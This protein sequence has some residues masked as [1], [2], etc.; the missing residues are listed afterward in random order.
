MKTTYF[1][2]TV[3]VSAQHIGFS[4]G[5]FD[6]VDLSGFR[7]VDEDD[8]LG[9]NAIRVHGFCLPGRADE[10]RNTCLP[11]AKAID[12]FTVTYGSFPFKSYKMVFVDDQVKDTVE[13]ASLSL[14]STR[15]LFPEDIIDPMDEVTRKLV[16]TLACQWIG[17][18]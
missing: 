9:S 7:E 13:T 1:N 4:A 5:P 18:N 17:I 6:H 12:F 16:H 11:M 3:P 10:V 14:C 8:K 2:C 15:I